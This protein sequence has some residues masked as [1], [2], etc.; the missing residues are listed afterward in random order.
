[1]P[2]TGPFEDRLAI[3]ELL[4]TYA[5]AVTR[6]DASA[7]GA[8]WAE[9]GEWS[10]PDYPEIG[11]TKGRDA[12]VAMWLEAMKAYPGIMFEAW[13]GSIEVEG[14]VARV[15][16]YTSEVYDQD[17][18]TKRDRGVYD[19]VCVKRDGTWQFRSRSFRNIHRQHAPKG[20]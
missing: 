18:Q 15:R 10:L 7:W 14:D 12:I 4:E 9:D 3:R 13:P 16:S 17:G 19:D 20:L 2:F 8:T 6:N 5:D 1:M 11:T